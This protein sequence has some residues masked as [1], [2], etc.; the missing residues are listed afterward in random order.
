M[1]LFWTTIFASMF[2]TINISFI[3][4]SFIPWNFNK[5]IHGLVGVW[6]LDCCCCC[7]CYFFCALASCFVFRVVSVAFVALAVLADVVSE[8]CC[9]KGIS[10]KMRMPI[11]SKWN[12]DVR[13]LGQSF[14][15]L[16]F[17]RT[18]RNATEIHLKL[19][20]NFSKTHTHARKHTLAHSLTSHQT[21]WFIFIRIQILWYHLQ[22]FLCKSLGS[23]A[24]IER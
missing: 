20:R 13:W 1:I 6:I 23:I 19:K 17:I 7:C 15:E 5:Y 22:S 12:S 16:T 8:F 3:N 9:L 21:R 18:F 2:Q 11:F 10:A 14:A 24:Q 4:D